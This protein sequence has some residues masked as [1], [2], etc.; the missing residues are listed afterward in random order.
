MGID[1][2]KHSNVS[3]KDDN[4]FKTGKDVPPSVRERL[5]ENISNTF[6]LI[7]SIDSS[8]GGNRTRQEWPLLN[9]PL[10]KS[11]TMENQVRIVDVAAITGPVTIIEDKLFVDSTKIQSCSV[12]SYSSTWT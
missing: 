11:F 4:V 5:P 10:N 8:F 7:Q 3:C 12:I 9:G 2:D 6:A 1:K